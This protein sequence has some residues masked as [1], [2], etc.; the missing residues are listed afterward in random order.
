MGNLTADDYLYED[1]EDF[2][3]NVDYTLADNYRHLDHVTRYPSQPWTIWSQPSNILNDIVSYD[4]DA[5][6]GFAAQMVVITS[7]WLLLC[8]A[9][10]SDFPGHPM[11]KLW[12]LYVPEHYGHRNSQHL[13]DPYR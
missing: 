8:L 13:L 4:G 6:P 1:K 11:G 12:P 3:T 9:F 10:M 2:Y 7:I 5:W